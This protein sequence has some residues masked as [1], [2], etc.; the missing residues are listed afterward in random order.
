MVPRSVLV[1]TRKLWPLGML[2]LAACASAPKFE[3]AGVDTALTPR[4]AVTLGEAA[5]GRRVQWGGAVVA[6]DNLENRTRLEVLAYP[7]DSRG[8]AQRDGAP[9]GRFLLVRD[10]YLEPVDY[11]PGRLV[12]A[13]GT[14][15]GIEEGQVG[16]APYRYP[17]LE[18]EQLHLW[19]QEQEYR[20]SNPQVHFGIGVILH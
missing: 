15:T 4:Q 13:V 16:A 5:V 17:V 20:R 8:R 6:V 11:A 18:A 3:T 14:I 2:L 7:L 1:V 9:Y 19:P 10:G 12:T